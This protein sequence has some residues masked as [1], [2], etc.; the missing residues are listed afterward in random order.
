MY[1]DKKFCNNI[2]EAA[3]RLYCH[4]YYNIVEK[5]IKI[6]LLYYSDN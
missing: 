4:Y 3:I 5:A 2:I 6:L 1:Y